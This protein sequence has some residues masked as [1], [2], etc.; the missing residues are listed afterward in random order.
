MRMVL[1]SL[2]KHLTSTQRK[3]ST[4]IHEKETLLIPVMPTSMR[5][6]INHTTDQLPSERIV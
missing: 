6:V 4:V 1:E 3:G 2:Q 5:L